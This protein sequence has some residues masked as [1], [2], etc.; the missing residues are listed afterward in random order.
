MIV[1]AKGAGEDEADVHVEKRSARHALL[2]LLDA[3]FLVAAGNSHEDAEELDDGRESLNVI[4]VDAETGEGVGILGIEL[5]GAEHFGACSDAGARGIMVFTA[6][7][8]DAG[9]QGKAESGV[10]VHFGGV[11]LRELS[12]GERNGVVGESEIGFVAG[13]LGMAPGF[14]HAI[15]DFSG[16]AVALPPFGFAFEKKTER[17]CGLGL[18][19]RTSERNGGGRV[20]AVDE[21]ARLNGERRKGQSGGGGSSGGDAGRK[22]EREE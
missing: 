3:Q 22:Q 8:V 17:Q 14:D 20:A 11:G 19:D 7:A 5:E 6:Q 18:L 15:F 1:L 13:D 10:D 2:H 16:G 12:L 9:F 4:V 21:V